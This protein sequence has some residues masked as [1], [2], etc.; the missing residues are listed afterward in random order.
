MADNAFKWVEEGSV[1]DTS[2]ELHQR[3]KEGRPARHQWTGD[4]IVRGIIVG[5]AVGT[6]G[7]VFMLL[8]SAIT[9]AIVFLWRAI[10]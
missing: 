5:G 7:A 2:Y 3:A 9:Y 6:L 10:L 4:E 8:I 1:E